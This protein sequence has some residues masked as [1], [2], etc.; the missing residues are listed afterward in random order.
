MAL[1]V[2][3]FNNASNS[4][5]QSLQPSVAG[6]QVGDLLLAVVSHRGGS[7]G[8]ISAPVGW[9]QLGVQQNSTTIL[10]HAV[11]WKLAAGG[12]SDPVF[13]FNTGTNVKGAAVL[14]IHRS[15]TG[16]DL[17]VTGSSHRV[18]AS[19]TN[20]LHDA[21]V[22]ATVS[23][24]VLLSSIANDSAINQVVGWT[25]DDNATSASGG[26]AVGT[27]NRSTMQGQ[28]F[29][30]ANP[31]SVTATCGTA[32][33]SCA[34]Q[35]AVYEIPAVELNLVRGVAE[36]VR[37]Q[38]DTR[39]SRSMARA[40]LE[41]VRSST[42]TLRQLAASY[43]Y[44]VTAMLHARE[45][46]RSLERETAVGVTNEVVSREATRSWM[47]D[48]LDLIRVVSES[49]GVTQT[50]VTAR[51][52]VR[53]MAE[54]VR[55]TETATRV[56]A[57]TLLTL[58]QVRSL[59]T[60]Q[61]M[62][63]LHRS[64]SEAVSGSESLL[65]VRAQIRHAAELVRAY[66]AIV[67]QGFADLIRRISEGVSVVDSRLHFRERLRLVTENLSFV[68]G[69]VRARTRV[70]MSLE[71]VRAVEALSAARGRV[72]AAFE[73]VGSSE[74]LT[75]ARARVHLAFD[76]VGAS[77]TLATSRARVRAAVESVRSS[78][79]LTR[80]RARVHLAVES[81]RALSAAVRLRE[82]V[83]LRSNT[84][85]LGHS[86]GSLRDRVRALAES[87]T[88]LTTHRLSRQLNR[89]RA[90]LVSTV[91][92]SV[93][94]RTMIRS[95]SSTLSVA[96]RV[97]RSILGTVIKVI[98][99]TV[100]TPEMAVYFGV[101]LLNMVLVVVEQIATATNLVR[102]RDRLVEILEG[103]VTAEDLSRLRDRHRSLSSAVVSG[104]A[105]VA[106]RQMTRVFDTYLLVDEASTVSR[107][108]GRIV[109]ASVRTVW[110]TTVHRGRNRAVSAR[111][112]VSA[113][114]TRTLSMVRDAWDRVAT[115]QTLVN[116]RDRVRAVRE[117][118]RVPTAVASVVGLVQLIAEYLSAS[119]VVVRL[120]DRVR[121]SYE[122]VRSNEASLSTRHM[123][124]L[125]VEV[126]RTHEAVVRTLARVRHV[127]E[128]LR[129]PALTNYL[130]GTF[131]TVTETMRHAEQFDAIR[132][133]AVILKEFV[134]SSADLV[135]TRLRVRRT[136]ES[137]RG[138]ETGSRFR[139]M[140]R[141]RGEAV[142]ALTGTS[143][144]RDRVVLLAEVASVA[145]AFIYTT[146]DYLAIMF[147]AVVVPAINGA[148]RVVN[149]L[150]SRVDA[151]PAI[152]GT[153]KLES[154]DG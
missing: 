22:A 67:E 129:I 45:Q 46:D 58:E 20:I 114:A 148:V 23:H 108:L 25:L 154:D 139:T 89:L 127:A 122:L 54:T 62:R 38:E 81:V 133:M 143:R 100:Q 91:E 149:I 130:R 44:V 106:A 73:S 59:E 30:T 42:A 18:N 150:G 85:S 27:R 144:Y 32:A 92:G 97:Y 2:V 3:G 152:T 48:V 79:T 119:E 113:A 128:S 135:R 138:Q 57:R 63:A 83:R 131:R 34:S 68:V 140:Q 136:A 111:L 43:V 141:V 52:R 10:A 109:T 21:V 13:N 101:A 118:L 84:L 96:D 77:E 88:T 69:E 60:T 125:A 117:E 5:A 12:E 64:L 151:K 39:R 110:S 102:V 90:E 72:R 103:T 53:A 11:F 76:S 47:L 16:G 107:A 126:L 123:L 8:T 121:E 134:S 40:L 65:R 112:D 9:Q 93:P 95:V 29:T 26:G 41:G 82:R 120:R 15:G 153:V 37:E 66:E 28:A 105:P 19:G 115:A 146:A 86:H 99:E 55:A 49:L 24:R 87:V 61:R 142:R 132:G 70:R 1:I 51:S 14:G 35:V 75:R 6:S 31:G 116:L 124:R 98:R 17:S 7:G 78:E 71:S 56:R 94:L 50:L 104:E 36:Q 80:A 33:V 145:S 137:V 147:R 74:T 4:A